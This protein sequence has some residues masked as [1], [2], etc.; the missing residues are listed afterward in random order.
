[1]GHLQLQMNCSWR[2]RGGR[3][4]TLYGTTGCTGSKIADFC[5]PRGSGVIH[6]MARPALNAAN[7]LISA[8]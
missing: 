2:R 1:M 6:C 7:K 4:H 8:P 3:C 5:A